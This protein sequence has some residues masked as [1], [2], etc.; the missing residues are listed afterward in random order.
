M[1]LDID[2]IGRIQVK[3][4]QILQI[5]KLNRTVYRVPQ[6]ADSRP[7]LRIF[8]PKIYTQ[9]GSLVRDLVAVSD[10]DDTPWWDTDPILSALETALE[11]LPPVKQHAKV[12]NQTKKKRNNRCQSA[13]KVKSSKPRKTSYPTDKDTV[14]KMQS[15]TNTLN[16]YI[17]FRT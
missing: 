2:S 13:T 4:K 7:V 9:L 11:R 6:V 8:Q 15:K 10:L 14:L 3:N 16:V 5:V 12:M 1:R 17:P